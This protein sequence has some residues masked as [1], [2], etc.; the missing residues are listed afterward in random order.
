MNEIVKTSNSDS[1]KLLLS[2]YKKSVSRINNT[3]Y[4]LEDEMELIDIL[5]AKKVDNSPEL[6]I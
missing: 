2:T 3:K 5:K 6:S 4:L 1:Y